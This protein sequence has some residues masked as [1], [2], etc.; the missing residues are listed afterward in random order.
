MIGTSSSGPIGWDGGRGL[1]DFGKETYVYLDS[2]SARVAL[3]EKYNAGILKIMY[4][5]F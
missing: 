3:R 5:L 2:S 1:D 4:V